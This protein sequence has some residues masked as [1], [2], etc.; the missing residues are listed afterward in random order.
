[1]SAVS[2]LSHGFNVMKG[3][4]ADNKYSDLNLIT[5]DGKAV[6]CHKVV[7]SSVSDKVRLMLD[8]KETSQL[9]LRNVSHEGLDNLIKFIYEGKVDIKSSEQSIKGNWTILHH[10]P[11]LQAEFDEIKV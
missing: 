7:L 5:V 2:V 1:M 8:Q 6:S 10:S 9:V 11:T 3:V 4:I